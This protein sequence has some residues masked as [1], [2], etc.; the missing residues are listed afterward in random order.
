MRDQGV[1]DSTRAGL[2]QGAADQEQSVHSGPSALAVAQQRGN[3]S[4]LPILPHILA[5]IF[6]VFAIAIVIL[7]LSIS[8]W[9]RPDPDHLAPAGAQLQAP[10][11]SSP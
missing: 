10:A 8:V 7:W 1:N 5:A 2:A 6:G 4:S 9:T 11:N 3:G